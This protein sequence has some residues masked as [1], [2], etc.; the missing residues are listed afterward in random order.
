LLLFAK[1][2]FLPSAKN[3]FFLDVPESN[4]DILLILYLAAGL[5]SYLEFS[6]SSKF[7]PLPY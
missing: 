7:L 4:F 2:D 3:V 6:F 1:R 5:F